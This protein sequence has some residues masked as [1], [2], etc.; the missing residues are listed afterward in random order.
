MSEQHKEDAAARA[1]YEYDQR[2]DRDLLGEEI[3]H[4]VTCE[5]CNRHPLPEDSEYDE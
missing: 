1:D 4:H 5:C 3:V 2:R